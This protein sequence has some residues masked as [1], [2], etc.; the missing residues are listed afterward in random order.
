MR[1][2][3]WIRQKE[4][5]I[6][7]YLPAYLG[8]DKEYASL[9]TACSI[10]HEA[11]RVAIQD[12]LDQLFIDTATWGLTTWEDF[13]DVTPPQ[14]S[15]YYNRRLQV[16]LKLNRNLIVNESFLEMLT[17]QYVNNGSADIIPHNEEYYFDVTFTK[18][19]CFDLSALTQAIEL[20]KPAHLG[21]KFFERQPVSVGIVI[22]CG[23][24]TAEVMHVDEEADYT[25]DP[26]TFGVSFGAV[27]G[28]CA[29]LHVGSEG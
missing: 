12:I 26:L 17:N 16:K 9:L 19:S 2:D 5:N 10:E 24:A 6:A 15:D 27:V 21:Y 22:G 28:E 4:V 25:V 14:M 3:S 1:T 13:V 23:A 29:V 18:D 8:K 20:Y 7:S 11:V